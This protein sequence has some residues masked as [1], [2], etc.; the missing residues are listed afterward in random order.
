MRA[1]SIAAVLCAMCVAAAASPG[2][3]K[4][5]SHAEVQACA[6]RGGAYQ[7]LGLLQT[8]VCVFPYPDGGK[9]CSDDS[10]CQGGCLAD[11][12]HMD[13]PL[14]AGER[15]KGAC[16]PTSDG[17]GCSTHVKNGRALNT[18]CVD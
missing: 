16:R 10:Q 1:H 14:R 9:T 2:M 6:A 11:V 7:R 5:P 15:V 12:G 8:S 18:M 3:S 17:F 4:E 13:R